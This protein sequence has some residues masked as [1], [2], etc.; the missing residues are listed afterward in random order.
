MKYLLVFVFFINSVYADDIQRIESVVKDIESL[1][2]KYKLSQEQLLIKEH[3]EK[4][5]I[6]KITTL[7]NQ[8]ILY[9][10]QLK[11]KDKILK[12]IKKKNKIKL[13][14]PV[15]SKPKIIYRIKKFENPNKFPVL[16]LKSRYINAQ[17]SKKRYKNR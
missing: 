4:K 1:R 14:K 12:K 17:S 2:K 8:I 5:Q 16:I 11:N 3:R 10:K 9:K 13:C 6:Q 7:K 15:K